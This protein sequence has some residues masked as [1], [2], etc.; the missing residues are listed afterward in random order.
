MKIDLGDLEQ[1]IAS[2]EQFYYKYRKQVDQLSSQV[3]S[4]VSRTK[5]SYSGE[6]NVGSMIN[7]VQNHLNTIK[8]YNAK[9]EKDIEICI[10]GLKQTKIMFLQED[11]DIQ[12]MIGGNP[13]SLDELNSMLKDSVDEGG[14][15]IGGV[16]A[17]LNGLIKWAKPFMDVGFKLKVDGKYIKVIFGSNQI[18]KQL[19]FRHKYL[20]SDI[21]KSK[22]LQKVLQFD[23]WLRM[24]K[25]AEN[26][27]KVG[28]WLGVAGIA[29]D[30]TGGLIENLDK[31]ASASEMIGDA[32]VDVGVGV[33]SFYVSAAAT[34]A[35]ATGGATIG[36]AIGTM[37]C[38]GVGSAVG[39]VIGGIVGGIG[40]AIG[41]NKLYN[42]IVSDDCFGLLEKGQSIEQYMKDC[43]T[44]IGDEIGDGLNW[45]GDQIIS[46]AEAVYDWGCDCVEAIG[47]AFNDSG[48][49]VG[50]LSFG[51]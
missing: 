29:L 12:N 33:G 44:W 11:Q 6:A 24:G 35:T 41:S 38:P 18:K 26:M 16:G 3:S 32:V 9:I 28:N 8:H 4:I 1:L 14:S 48:K 51:W 46:G 15:W 40:G 50:G 39:G 25:Y 13:L 2:Y 21:G 34:Q 27:N 36:A 20:L 7:K 17:G 30:T 19:G 23:K 43:T 10:E 31:K 45:M 49:K 42:E 22:E 37:I 5:S 47:D